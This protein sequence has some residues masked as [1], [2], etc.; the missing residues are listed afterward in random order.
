MMKRTTPSL[1]Q[2]GGSMPF[3]WVRP[4]NKTTWGY[5]VKHHSWRLNATKIKHDFARGWTQ[6]KHKNRR[7]RYSLFKHGAPEEQLIKK[8]QWGDFAEKLPT[9]VYYSPGAINSTNPGDNYFIQ[10]DFAPEFSGNYEVKPFVTPEIFPEDHP[11]SRMP[12]PVRNVVAQAERNRNFF[13]KE[14]WY[15]KAEGDVLTPFEILELDVRRVGMHL[16]GGRHWRMMVTILVSNGRGVAGLGIGEAQNYDEAR[17]K[18]VENAF[19][20]LIAIDTDDWTVPHPLM[21]EFNKTKLQLTPS[22]AIRT[23]PMFADVISGIGLKG[24]SLSVV[25][26]KHKKYKKL[27]ILFGILRQMRSKREIAQQRGLSLNSIK[28]P[29]LSY[30]EQVRR[31]RGMF[32]MQPPGRSTFLAPNRVI[33]NRIPDHLKK[34]FFRGT[35]DEDFGRISSSETFRYDTGTERYGKNNTNYLNLEG[36]ETDDVFGQYRAARSDTTMQA[37]TK[38]PVPQWTKGHQ[39][40]T[41]HQWIS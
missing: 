24:L 15:N 39:S 17:N 32:E 31:N 2:V 33:D 38:F 12:K 25:G 36:Q 26:S 10:N 23:S 8:L 34:K 11:L 20:N 40:D 18:G 19:G 14:Q 16:Q 1:G 28:G 29:M 9:S 37:K 5:I 4:D 13:T 30:Y 22:L 41:R 27:M 7:W 35:D 6:T 21:M 3:N